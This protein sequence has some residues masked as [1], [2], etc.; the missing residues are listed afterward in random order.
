MGGQHRRPK[1]VKPTGQPCAVGST[2]GRE[3]R[4][5]AASPV[6]P[7][8][9]PAGAEIAYRQPCPIPNPTPDCPASQLSLT[10]LATSS[11]AHG[12]TF[13]FNLRIGSTFG[14]EFHRQREEGDDNRQRPAEPCSF[15][16]LHRRIGPIDRAAGHPVRCVARSAA[17][18]I[19]DR[20][21]RRESPAPTS[22]TVRPRQ[23]MSPRADA[24]CSPAEGIA[25][26]RNT[27]LRQYATRRKCLHANAFRILLDAQ[28]CDVG[29]GELVE[30]PIR[31]IVL[32]LAGRRAGLDGLCGR[33]DGGR[34]TM[35]ALPARTARRPLC[36]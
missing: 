29:E 9:N 26:V 6:P 24:L 2:A 12:G 8:T 34:Q 22:L 16:A 31:N 7:G 27:S 17:P 33:V 13:R 36:G 32:V 35:V 19:E 1:P 10:A 18:P 28:A 14:L 11:A 23:W 25:H 30:G 5:R 4:F 3:S 15:S 20:P 21:R